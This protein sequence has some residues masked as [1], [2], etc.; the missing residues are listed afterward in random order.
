M[1]TDFFGTLDGKV[2]NCYAKLIVS[3][4]GSIDVSSVLKGAQDAKGTEAF[5]GL[6]DKV[7]TI[8]SGSY[9]LVTLAMIFLFLCG[10]GVAMIKLFFSN[11]ATRQESKSDVI[12]KVVA[13]ILGFAVVGLIGVLAGVGKGLFG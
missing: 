11:G 6:E 2:G 9:R 1:L 4:D 10:F 3:R 13:A 12:W 7:Q 8:G 5:S